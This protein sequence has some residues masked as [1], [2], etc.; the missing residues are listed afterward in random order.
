MTSVSIYVYRWR[1]GCP[2][3]ESFDT[4]WRRFCPGNS[5]EY[6]FLRNLKKL[7][8]ASDSMDISENFLIEL[9][10]QSPDNCL[11]EMKVL[12]SCLQMHESV[13]N[14]EIKFF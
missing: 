12:K 4:C 7:K 9:A 11:D 1:P 2:K 5:P 14:G 6:D 3:F 13:N 8:A 10:T